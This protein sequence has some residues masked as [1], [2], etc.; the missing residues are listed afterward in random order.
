MS[1]YRCS[2]P[3]FCSGSSPR[4]ASANSRGESTSDDWAPVA[5]VADA[6]RA[7]RGRARR[8]RARRGP[9]AET[10]KGEQRRCKTAVRRARDAAAAIFAR[11]PRNNAAGRG[12]VASLSHRGRDRRHHPERPATTPR[13]LPSKSVE[14]HC[15]GPLHGGFHSASDTTP[16]TESF[17][18][19]LRHRRVRS[20]DA[21]CGGEPGWPRLLWPGDR[22]CYFPPSGWPSPDHNPDRRVDRGVAPRRRALA[23]HDTSSRSHPP[24]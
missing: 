1:N 5:R 4:R 24:R 14:R 2:A 15:R 16:A 9:A 17:D 7:A 22:H 23:E 19:V 8:G 6:T 18:I 12:E 10:R 13:A 21:S 3:V 11:G 20:F